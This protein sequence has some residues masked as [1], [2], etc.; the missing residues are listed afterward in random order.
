MPHTINN[1]NERSRWFNLL[2][3]THR[4]QFNKIYELVIKEF[5][6]AGH[7]LSPVAAIKIALNY[8]ISRWLLDAMIVI[9]ISPSMIN[10]TEASQLPFDM[11]MCLWRSREEYRERNYSYDDKERAKVVI[12]KVF[13]KS[14]CGFYI[15]KMD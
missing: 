6:R 11:L 12:R 1:A 13:E 8:Q 3:I 4:Y 15:S 7:G 2:S 5:N 9:V 14:K 10:D